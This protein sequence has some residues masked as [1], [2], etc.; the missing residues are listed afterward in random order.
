MDHCPYCESVRSLLLG[1]VFCSRHA[2]ADMGK[3]E[4]GTL[5]I[6]TQRLEETAEHVSR[7][8]IRLMLNGEQWYK[9]GS[10]DR[11]VHAGN[12][13]VVNQG[14]RYRTAFSG[15]DAMEMIMVGFRPGQAED[16]FRS[17]TERD[18]RLLDEPFFTG[19]TIGFFEQ[20]YPNDAVITGHF[21]HLRHLM[22]APLAE[23]HGTD[24]FAIHTA[25]L[26]RLIHLQFGVADTSRRLPQLRR[27][28]RLEVWRRL[29][30]ARDLA[31]ARF[32]EDLKVPYLARAAS[33]STHHF[34]RTFKEAFGVT[35]HRYVRGV[36]LER[37]Q[38]MFKTGRSSIQDVASAVGYS[39]PSAFVRLY[40]QE[41]GRTPGS[42]RRT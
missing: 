28:T 22:D 1:N 17:L 26:E 18:E 41:F 36:R 32:G 19:P 13:L 9:V 14:Q 6:R 10:T 16:V 21:R 35:P 37:A 12:F 5:F 4:N 40:K 33:M 20:T 11:R 38:A 42:E 27:S 24:L 30:I 8:S 23:R 7:L 2:N 39:D 15:R 3:L 34:K 31:E 29:N 25:L